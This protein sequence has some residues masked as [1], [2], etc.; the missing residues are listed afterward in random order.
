M[1]R[2]TI[3]NCFW[4]FLRENEGTIWHFV[5]VNSQAEMS[6]ANLLGFCCSIISEQFKLICQA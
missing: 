5:P 3:F 1:R 4:R 6:V 2:F